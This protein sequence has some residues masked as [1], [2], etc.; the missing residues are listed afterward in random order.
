MVELHFCDNLNQIYQLFSFLTKRIW[1][2]IVWKAINWFLSYMYDYTLSMLKSPV[3]FL[4][5]SFYNLYMVHASQKGGGIG[6]VIYIFLFLIIYIIVQLYRRKFCD[7]HIILIY[8]V[9][10]MHSRESIFFAS[11][12]RYRD[13]YE[14][15]CFEVPWFQNKLLQ[16]IQIKYSTCVSYWDATWIFLWRSDK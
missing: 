11:N 3:L 16:K 9:L 1:K 8:F 10:P 12:F 13:F 14:L 7:H 15:I 4:E 2:K 5:L 6:I